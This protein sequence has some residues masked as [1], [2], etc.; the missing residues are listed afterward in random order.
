MSRIIDCFLIWSYKQLPR[1]YKQEDK[2][3]GHTVTMGSVRDI[4]VA[5]DVQQ[6][7]LFVRVAELH[8]TEYYGKILIV[9]Q[10]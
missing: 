3:S 9:E 8:V 5:V 2:K 7:I 1:L 6:C 4:I 10:Q